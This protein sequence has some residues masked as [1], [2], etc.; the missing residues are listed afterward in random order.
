MSS[1]SVSRA[2]ESLT[3]TVNRVH[4]QGERV[5][6]KRHGKAVAAIVSVEDLERLEKVEDLLD[7][8][9]A[10]KALKEKGKELPYEE[11]RKA[12]GL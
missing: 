7:A 10:K 2:R 9:A 11:F 1:L 3:D 12:L 8:Q 5:I 6:L 4:Y